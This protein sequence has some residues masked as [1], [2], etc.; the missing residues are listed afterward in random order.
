MKAIFVYKQSGF[1]PR[2]PTFHDSIDHLRV[3]NLF[4]GK[5]CVFSLGALQSVDTS[6]RE[7]QVGNCFTGSLVGAGVGGRNPAEVSRGD[8]CHAIDF[9]CLKLKLPALYQSD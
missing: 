6:S 8:P 5:T 1:S 3:Q 4:A 7:P 2:M 9:E